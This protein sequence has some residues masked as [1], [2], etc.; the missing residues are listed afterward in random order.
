[1]EHPVH[2]PELKKYMKMIAWSNRWDQVILR[3]CLIG[4]FTAVGTTIGFALLIIIA[5]QFVTTFKQIP[6]LDAFL[7]QTKL[8]VLIENQLQK[9][10][11]TDQGQNPPPSNNNENQTPTVVDLKYNNAVYKLAFTYP[12]TF[13][14]NSET[15]GASDGGRVVQLAGTGSLRSLD[16]YIN[17]PVQVG[18]V[19]TQRI[20]PRN[21]INRI[22]VNIYDSGAIVNNK[23]IDTAVYYSEVKVGDNTFSFVGIADSQTPKLAREIFVNILTSSTFN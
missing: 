6:L 5:G 17:E 23:K 8:D 7:A 1:M 10:S 15:A 2:D 22:V 21:D 16:V 18:G 3:G 19:S 4:V 9:I 12:S 13:T 20:I 14:S 11:Q